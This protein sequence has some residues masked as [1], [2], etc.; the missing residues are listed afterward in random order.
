MLLYNSKSL[1]RN[2]MHIY[3]FDS[4]AHIRDTQTIKPL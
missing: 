4:I 1:Q 2:K 3:I